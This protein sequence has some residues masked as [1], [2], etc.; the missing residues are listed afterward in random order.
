M[1]QQL[2]NNFLTDRGLQKY[3]KTFNQHNI[4]W[5]ELR[6]L[7]PDDLAGMGIISPAVQKKILTAISS[8]SANAS[9]F[10]SSGRPAA[11]FSTGG[12]GPASSQYGFSS[13][14]LQQKPGPWKLSPSLLAEKGWVAGGS[15]GSYYKSKELEEPY[16]S[17]LH[18]KAFDLSG[19]DINRVEVVH[20][21]TSE[22]TFSDVLN[23]FRTAPRPRGQFDTPWHAGLLARLSRLCRQ[24]T[25]DN[26]GNECASCVP[27]LYLANDN[28]VKSICQFNV[29]GT[30]AT[31]KGGIR[32]GLSIKSLLGR[33]AHSQQSSLFNR[34]QNITSAPNP[35]G[36]GQNGSIVLIM[37]WLLLGKVRPCMEA[38][39]P[40]FADYDTYYSTIALPRCEP[41]DPSFGSN[42][43]D[44]FVVF[45]SCQVLPQYVIHLHPTIPVGRPL[46]SGSSRANSRRQHDTSSFKLQD[47]DNFNSSS[48]IAFGSTTPRNTNSYENGSSATGGSSRVDSPLLYGR[49]STPL[50]GNGSTAPR[51]RPLLS[52]TTQALS[53]AADTA[54]NAFS[55]VGAPSKPNSWMTTTGNSPVTPARSGGSTLLQP[56]PPPGSNSSGGGRTMM[57]GWTS[58]A[59]SASSSLPANPPPPSPLSSRPSHSSRRRQYDSSSAAEPPAQST[60]PPASTPRDREH[61]NTGG[62]YIWSNPPAE[63]P[64]SPP[65]LKRATVVLKASGGGDT[66]DLD[67]AMS[68]AAPGDIV[69]IHPGTYQWPLSRPLHCSLVGVGDRNS[70]IIEGPATS[71][72]ISLAE[73][74]SGIRIDN[75]TLKGNTAVDS[76]TYVHVEGRVDGFTLKNVQM[77]HLAPAARVT[78]RSVGVTNAA[79]GVFLGKG[80]SNVQVQ[81]CDIMGVKWG[82]GCSLQCKGVKVCNNNIHDCTI[83]IF[84]DDAE[85]V[86]TGNYLRNNEKYDIWLC[87]AKDVYA[88]KNDTE[89]EIEQD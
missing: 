16:P 72:F 27:V 87:S 8:T 11:G 12:Y 34:V 45:D 29:N 22:A 79:F 89:K 13:A 64:P 56:T 55:S 66:T 2:L 10:A 17:L 44:E 20:N 53:M 9:M 69:E 39:P 19:Y 59:S 82:V 4:T 38:N 88:V 63:E 62:A 50:G 23:H 78:S 35:D 83:G 65:P 24:H 37:C 75:L 5:G 18:S 49:V 80:A 77:T 58:S 14:I 30:G 43:H 46:S 7:T 81:Y 31:G 70:V 86:V 21:D 3:A 68:F 76:S 71:K 47:K 73:G 48:D 26:N 61:L 1:S 33:R 41:V 51:R 28:E 54:E 25:T 6:N 60:P 42:V 74:A 84:V 67:L 52:E 15:S 57:A 32:F 36:L 85:V 40:Q